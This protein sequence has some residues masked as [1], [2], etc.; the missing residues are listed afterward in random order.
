M[1]WPQF[2]TTHNI[3]Y[4]THGANLSKGNIGIKCPFCGPADKSQHMNISIKGKGWGCWRDPD[5]RGMSNA[6]LIQ[7]L[8]NCS[9]SEARAL[10]GS[11][12]E[13][14]LDN[15]SLE[16]EYA[17]IYRDQWKPF[18]ALKPPRTWKPLHNATGLTAK[19]IF[20]YLHDDRRY[21]NTDANILAKRYDLQYT[22]THGWSNRI[23]FPIKN[24]DYQL[25]NY[26]GRTIGKRAVNRYKMMDGSEA[27]RRMSQSLLDLPR[28][29]RTQGKVLACVEGPFDAV[30]V[31]WL[32]ETFGIYAT[33]SFTASI[34]EQQAVALRTLSKNFER[35]VILFDSAATLAASA[36]R[37][38]IGR[39]FVD[40]ESIPD[41][42]KDPDDLNPQ[43]LLELCKQLAGYS[44]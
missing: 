17:Q 40:I 28:L 34:S 26:T 32:G 24:V 44:M 16:A 42:V 15:E 21:T 19:L 39:H 35:T 43:Q 41:D 3:E 5:H 6:R 22:H 27:P 8:I 9:W 33:C 36:A 25:V 29:A 10:A 14:K 4:V 2:L 12:E 30:R 37:E 13:V 1:D 23:I 38:M 11:K 7:A 18:A 31:S 20:N